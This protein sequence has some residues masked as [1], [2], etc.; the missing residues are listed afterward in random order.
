MA[1][2]KVCGRKLNSGRFCLDH[3]KEKQQYLRDEA[4]RKANYQAPLCEVCGKELTGG[5]RSR[6]CMAHNLEYQRARRAEANR[7]REFISGWNGDLVP[8]AWDDEP[9]QVP[10]GPTLI[11][12]IAAGPRYNLANTTEDFETGP[13]LKE[14]RAGLSGELG[15]DVGVIEALKISI[16][17]HARE[18]GYWD[19]LQTAP[20]WRELQDEDE[21]HWY[22]V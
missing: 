11:S 5:R 22:G 12:P 21:T 15:H 7:P 4:K 16:E 18:N 13:T 10:V 17:K 9:E 3:Q 1:E 6:F 8:A 20:R 14:Y 19:Q 2:C